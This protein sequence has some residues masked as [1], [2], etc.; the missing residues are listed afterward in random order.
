MVGI[1]YDFQQYTDG[2][3]CDFTINMNTTMSLENNVRRI[4][5]TCLIFIRVWLFNNIWNNIFTEEK[6]PAASGYYFAHGVKCTF[7]GTCCP[8][9]V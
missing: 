9:S 6:W 2:L 7:I 5:K 3:K 1:V 4:K 8:W